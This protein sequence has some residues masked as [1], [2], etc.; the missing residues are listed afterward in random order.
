MALLSK[1]IAKISETSKTELGLHSNYYLWVLQ[2][3][4]KAEQAWYYDIE[5][6]TFSLAMQ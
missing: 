3:M 1:S 5:N 4:T 6:L 2:H